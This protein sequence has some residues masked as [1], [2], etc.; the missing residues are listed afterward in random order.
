M[1]RVL[2]L[3]RLL[4]NCLVV[5][6]ITDSLSFLS[7]ASGRRSEVINERESLPWDVVRDRARPQIYQNLYT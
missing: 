1:A 2:V 5:I 6:E 7:Y 4:K 3:V